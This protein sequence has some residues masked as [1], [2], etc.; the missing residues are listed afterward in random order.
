MPNELTEFFRAQN[1]EDARS[2]EELTLAYAAQYGAQNLQQFPQFQQEFNQIVNEAFPP[3]LGDR[4]RQALRQLILGASSTIES[5][6]ESLAGIEQLNRPETQ[7]QDL[8]FQ[9]AAGGIRSGAEAIAPEEVPSLRQSFLGSKVPQGLGSA[10][11]FIGGGV[12]GTALKV[13]KVLTIAGLGAASSAA[14]GRREAIAAGADTEQQFQALVANAPVG[15]TE[16]FPLARMFNRLDR[17]SGGTLKKAVIE[18]GKNSLEEATQEAFQGAAGDVIAKNIVQFDE[19]RELFANTFEDFAVGGIVGGLLGGANQAILRK[20]EDIDSESAAD[21]KERVEQR[22]ARPAQPTVSQQVPPIGRQPQQP[23]TVQPQ[24]TQ[25]EPTRV[26]IAALPP[27]QQTTTQPT[28]PQPD[29][30]QRARQRA[31]EAAIDVPSTVIALPQTTST[32]GAVT[33]VRPAQPE[34]PDVPAPSLGTVGQDLASVRS[35]ALQEAIEPSPPQ[36]PK[37]SEPAPVQQQAEEEQP[38]ESPLVNQVAFR[39]AERPDTSRR[40]RQKKSGATQARREDLVNRA[41]ENI[42]KIPQDRVRVVSGTLSGTEGTLSGPGPRKGTRID[43]IEIKEDWVKVRMDDGEVVEVPESSVASLRSL[44]EDRLQKSRKAGFSGVLEPEPVAEEPQPEPQAEEQQV[45]PAFFEVQ[46]IDASLPERLI[47]NASP[48]GSKSKSLTSRVTVFEN[49]RTGNFLVL[50]TFRR[51]ADEGVLVT[52]PP[53]IAG[54]GKTLAL[55]RAMNEGLVPVASLLLEDSVSATD[56]SN[57]SSFPDQATF[58]RRFLNPLRER[59]QAELRTSAA[60]EDQ[61]RQ[62]F[63]EAVEESRVSDESVEA[64]DVGLRPGPQA[65]GVAVEPDVSAERLKVADELKVISDAVYEELDA[66]NDSEQQLTE[67][68]T[69]G[70]LQDIVEFGTGQEKQA[71]KK[72]MSAYISQDFGQKEIIKDVRRRFQESFSN[73]STSQ[74]FAEH[75]SK[76]GTQG[77][78]QGQSRSADA[79]NRGR[80]DSASSAPHAS[81]G[82]DRVRHRSPT[83]GPPERGY[84]DSQRVGEAFNRVIDSLRVRGADV[85]LVQE[86]ILEDAGQF[87]NVDGGGAVHGNMVVLVMEDITRPNTENLTAALHET[88]HFLYA[89]ESQG[90]QQKIHAA[91]QKMS[92]DI[93][94]I[95]ESADERIRQGNPENLTEQEL[96]EERLAEA[97]ALERFDAPSS[98]S[99]AG[100]IWRTIADL[101][102]RFLMRIQSAILGPNNISPALA[103]SYMR[104]RLSQHLNGDPRPTDFLSWLGGGNPHL[105][106]EIQAYTPLGDGLMP[107]FYDWRANKIRYQDVVPESIDA[108][109]ANLKAVLGQGKLRR[110]DQLT[111]P[112]PISTDEN[113][114]PIDIAANNDLRNRLIQVFDSWERA[115]RNTANISADEFISQTLRSRDPS[116]IIAQTLEDAQNA[117]ITDLNPGVVPEE[118]ESNEFTGRAR[119]KSL[120]RLQKI[121]ARLGT[122]AG[123]AKTDKEEATNKIGSLNDRMKTLSEKF[124]DLDFM[125]NEARQTIKGLLDGYMRDLRNSNSQG[126][127]LGMLS[128]SLK[129]LEN[130]LE[131]GAPRQFQQI[132]DKMFRRITGSTD[133]NRRFMDLLTA[134]AELDLDWENSPLI[135]RGDRVGLRDQIRI[136]AEQNPALQEIS[137]STPESRALLAM[138]AAFAKQQNHMMA[139]LRLRQS[140]DQEAISAVRDLIR[141]GLQDSSEDL[142]EARKSLRKVPRFAKEAGKV[143]EKL[144]STKR[145]QQSLRRQHNRASQTI[146]LHEVTAS[147][148]DEQ[149]R[150]LENL[151]GADSQFVLHHNSPIYNPTSPDATEQQVKDS[152]VNY[153]QTSGNRGQIIRN[154]EQWLAAHE[155]DKGAFWNTVRQQ[156]DQLKNAEAQ[157]RRIGIQNSWISN[158]FGSI[159]DWM[160]NTGTAAGR[161]AADKMTKFVTLTDRWNRP[162]LLQGY[163]WGRAFGDA[164]RATGIKDR[165]LFFE[166]FYDKPI[167]FIRSRSELAEQPDG[168]TQALEETRQMLLNDPS[169]AS[170]MAQPNV[171]SSVRTLLDRSRENS[172]FFDS[173]RREMGI[174]VDDTVLGLFREAIGDPG[175]TVPRGM[176]ERLEGLHKKMRGTWLPAATDWFKFSNLRSI[177]AQEFQALAPQIQSLF[178]EDVWNEFVRPLVYRPGRSAFSGTRFDD[179]KWPVANRELVI[180][181]FESAAGDPLAFAS[182]LYQLT[183][184]Q[185]D[186]QEFVAETLDTFR[187]YFMDVHNQLV[188]HEHAETGA[189]QI[190]SAPRQLMDARVSDS[191][192]A[193]WVRYYRMDHDT[194]RMIIHEL[195]YHASFG[196]EGKSI[197]TDFDQAIRQLEADVAELRDIRAK[198]VKDNPGKTE[199]Q[200]RR[201]IQTEARQRGGNNYL[202]VLENSES[203][204][205]QA[206]KARENFSGWFAANREGL[207]EMRPF[208]ELLSTIVSLMV[209]SAK[210]AFIDTMTIFNPLVTQGLSRTSINQ[211]RK[212]IGSFANEV[213]GTFWQTFNVTVESNSENVLRRMRS[214]RFDTDAQI[215]IRDRV[216]AIWDSDRPVMVRA[217]RV[218]REA[219]P[220]AGISRSKNET[221]RFQSLKPTAP[222]TMGVGWM[223]A[224]IIDGVWHSYQDMIARAVEFLEANPQIEAQPEID[225]TAEQLGYKKG[226]ILDDERGFRHL[227]AG[228]QR[229]GMTLEG[230]ARA[231]LERRRATGDTVL[232]TDEQFQR[233]AALATTELSLEASITS[234]PGFFTNPVLNFAGKLLGWSMSRV[235]QLQK[236]FRD[237]DGERSLYA[238]K[239]GMA[240]LGAAVPLGLAYAALMQEYDEELTGKKSNIRGFGQDNNFLAAV[241]QLARVGTFGMWGDLAN[242]LGNMAGEGDLRGLSV[243]HRVVFINSLTNAM[244]ALTTAVKQRDA[245]YAGVIRP[246]MMSLGGSGYLQTAQILNNAL[247][248]DNAETRVVARINVNNYLRSVGRELNMEVRTGGSFRSLPNPIKP[249]VNRMLMSAYAND[250]LAFE[251]AY[252]QAIDAAVREG[253]QDPVDHVRR[254]YEGR[255]PLSLIFRTKPSDQEVGLMISRLPE[256]GAIAV[257]EALDL[258]EIYGDTIAKQ[259]QRRGRQPSIPSRGLTGLPSFSGNLDTASIRQGAL[260]QAVSGF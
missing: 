227:K 5:I 240:V 118:F 250:P 198:A 160:R 213:W 148:I 150:A 17:V 157:D 220:S 1:P 70:I 258:F 189:V 152:A 77:A 131:G 183:G 133:S 98:R 195:S 14:E 196:R 246:M 232:M 106:R 256:D 43:D 134:T 45:E 35:A 166:L 31:L 248:L 233:L 29:V 173:V 167:H 177:E 76:A 11:G 86:G 93:L 97:L 209:Q 23:T 231:A 184:A 28:A 13:P 4:G 155:S 115:G 46:T 136:A 135:S 58:Q 245:D 171:W 80:R 226:I 109:R 243:D 205:R 63:T 169:T 113:R 156:A 164:F 180:E 260:L 174:K 91:V 254:S 2:D 252:R 37:P 190:M 238:V 68:A 211:I 200:L 114:V 259:P 38:D 218:I 55:N 57:I 36:P 33:P 18:S 73:A 52:R 60:V 119:V 203:H 85:R 62:N 214:G 24:P 191:W 221:N 124:Q 51:K 249:H 210:T 212:T 207:I 87:F 149:I 8:L 48:I 204:R 7:T 192:P 94:G 201:I 178:T 137:G 234:R 151:L 105:S 107:V 83:Q 39:R 82:D 199:K 120:R 215:S 142:K 102:S 130:D 53:G 19:D 112:E 202:R 225:L 71:V 75:L 81:R 208:H 122:A 78:S 182:A 219:L 123:K 27:A 188:K 111:D 50:P 247:G 101:A 154:L 79:G 3:T 59:Q 216:R 116:A 69:E 153:D 9:Q 22:K 21:V 251:D 170:F 175:F 257:Q 206:R 6:P 84:F 145:R 42:K 236:S 127:S 242:T 15:L 172:G 66:L 187:N 176:H 44:L 26:P 228:L 244:H 158:V 64:T 16:I 230:L 121:R 65:G 88:V 54:K 20:A 25:P 186:Q 146:D 239:S 147:P 89:R 117:G 90:M 56:P 129:D 140:N 100:V 104:N 34:P 92:D 96:A 49:A 229:F 222:F 179:G 163:K 194:S 141:A 181:A 139:L 47:S 72:L 10:L 217:A 125:F 144:Q 12:A 162:G 32:S 103:V 224:A 138:V 74:E 126:Y 40:G 235:N 128:Q 161:M 143:L 255:N 67:V 237:P 197:Y 185:G 110:P 132:L 165:E 253:K 223:N 99:I 41:L 159:S 168:W 95:T 193:E 30:R 241:E 108:A 61:I